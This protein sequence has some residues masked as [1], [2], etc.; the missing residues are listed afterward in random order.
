M[1]VG[2]SN[3]LE[4]WQDFEHAFN[5]LDPIVVHLEQNPEEMANRPGEL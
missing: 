2:N 3:C 1:G 4:F 5:L